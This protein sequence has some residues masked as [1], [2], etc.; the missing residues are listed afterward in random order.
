MRDTWEAMAWGERIGQLF[1]RQD[2]LERELAI[3]RDDLKAISHQVRRIVILVA[4]GGTAA[5]TNMKAGE[6]GEL[7][8]IVIKGVIR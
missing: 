1:A 5:M 7:L 2:R 8:A 3:V 6:L 4:L